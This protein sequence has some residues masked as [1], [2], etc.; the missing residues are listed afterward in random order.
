MIDAR[1]DTQRYAYIA[2]KQYHYDNV[3]LDF[4]K[5]NQFLEDKMRGIIRYKEELLNIDMS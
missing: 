5:I 4:D 1:I 3:K 2:Q